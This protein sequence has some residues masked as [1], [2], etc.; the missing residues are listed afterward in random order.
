M[1]WSFSDGAQTHHVS[2]QRQG[3]IFHVQLGEARYIARLLE[4]RAPR[5]TLLL[6]DHVVIESSV[7]W[8]NGTCTLHL[9]NVPHEICLVA[10]HASSRSW[11][12][13]RPSGARP[14]TNEIRAPL[15]GRIVDILVA[16]GDQITAGQPV[17]IIEAMKMQN[18]IPAPCSGTVA[19][20]CVTPGTAVEQQ[21]TLIILL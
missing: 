20:V 11:D 6:D 14:S 12:S 5:M 10:D 4:Y 9:H 7:A 8:H 18:E 17:C 15:P 1:E 13:V 3:N 2:L 21:T 16:A 19:T